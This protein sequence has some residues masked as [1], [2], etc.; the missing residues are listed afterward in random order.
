MSVDFEFGPIT[1][2]LPDGWTESGR[3]G[4]RIMFISDDKQEHATISHRTYA[5]DPG[6]TEFE[7]MCEDRLARERQA[8]QDGFLETKGAI[9]TANGYTLIFY[10]GDKATA[11]MFSGLLILQ[12]EILVAIYLEGV[13]IEPQRHMDSFGVFAKGCRI[14]RLPASS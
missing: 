13:A 2:S 4:E 11:R 1:L 9:D 6:F 10:G 5:R 8:L 7:A 12:G 14:T 3:E